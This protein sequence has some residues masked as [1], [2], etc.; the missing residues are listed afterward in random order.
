MALKAWLPPFNR[1]AYG[2]EDGVKVVIEAFNLLSLNFKNSRL[3]SARQPESGCKLKLLLPLK[4]LNK[5]KI[6][7][8]GYVNSKQ[9]HKLIH[10]CDIVIVLGRNVAYAL[11]GYPF[12]L[13]K[14][15]AT[16]N[17]V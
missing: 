2:L 16:G 1:G 11:G 14:Y 8:K 9:Y 12:K 5:A 13:G 4:N 17:A 6:S 15:M 7:H 3:I 10:K